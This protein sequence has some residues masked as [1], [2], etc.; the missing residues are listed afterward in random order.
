MEEKLF[1]PAFREPHVLVCSIPPTRYREILSSRS[2][3]IYFLHFL[4]FRPF[5]CVAVE[6]NFYLLGLASVPPAATCVCAALSKIAVFKERIHMFID[7][8]K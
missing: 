3:K 4:P 2:C 7:T 6:H 5:V 8:A 1:S